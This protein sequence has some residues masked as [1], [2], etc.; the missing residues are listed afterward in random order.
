MVLERANHLRVSA[1]YAGEDMGW[2]A[3]LPGVMDSKHKRF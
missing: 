3:L 1:D 2:R